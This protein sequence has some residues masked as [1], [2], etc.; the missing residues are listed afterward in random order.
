MRALNRTPSLPPSARG[1]S[2]LSSYFQQPSRTPAQD[3]KDLVNWSISMYLL[4]VWASALRTGL[5][6]RNGF[7]RLHSMALREI[8]LVNGWVQAD[9]LSIPYKYSV[10]SPCSLSKNI[11]LEE[12]LPCLSWSC[13]SSTSS[14]AYCVG[15][16]AL[17]ADLPHHVQKPCKG[18]QC[19]L[20]LLVSRRL[21]GQA[22]IRANREAPGMGRISHIHQFQ[23]AVA[24]HTSWW[25]RVRSAC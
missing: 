25:C 14:P 12:T 15:N 18:Q 13:W 21:S 24:Q 11:S 7:H 4:M 16:L 10:P 6:L 9:F 1:L 3:S 22:V 19:L 5:R 8:I 17:T 20:V 23:D 2:F